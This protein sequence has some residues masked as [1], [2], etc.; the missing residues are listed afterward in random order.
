M[1]V[2]GDYGY[3][4]QGRRRRARDKSEGVADVSGRLGKVAAALLL[5]PL[6]W[7]SAAL[8]RGGRR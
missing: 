4:F 5:P 2:Y 6:G 7:L 1:S 8:D 3:G